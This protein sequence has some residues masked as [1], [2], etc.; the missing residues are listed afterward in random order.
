MKK[1]VKS[2][3]VKSMLQ[4]SIVSNSLLTEE[5]CFKFITFFNLIHRTINVNYITDFVFNLLY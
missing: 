1:L 5:V 3:L 4:S 2:V